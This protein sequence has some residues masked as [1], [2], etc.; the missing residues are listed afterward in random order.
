MDAETDAALPGLT[1]VPLLC[2]DFKN[3]SECYHF[4]QFLANG[5]KGTVINRQ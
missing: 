4:L 5:E 1:L 2:I 3:R